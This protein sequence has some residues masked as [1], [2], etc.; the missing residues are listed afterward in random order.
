MNNEVAVTRRII[1]TYLKSTG[2]PEA[3]KETII[4]AAKLDEE[5]FLEHIKALI[6]I[7]TTAK[8]ELE[9]RQSE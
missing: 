5:L 3:F 9:R 8:E 1:T 2:T 6:E 7:F 4:I